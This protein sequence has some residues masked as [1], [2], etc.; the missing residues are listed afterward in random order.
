MVSTPQRV[1]TDWE[2]WRIPAQQVR[3]VSDAAEAA[4][5]LRALQASLRA[6]AAAARRMA[7]A[8]G[9]AA[10]RADARAEVESLVEAARADFEADVRGL[11]AHMAAH[12]ADLA[13]AI[14]RRLAGSELGHAFV[15][16]AAAEAA[17]SLIGDAPLRV[18]CHPSAAAA[19]KLQLSDILPSADVQADADAAPDC[20]VFETRD[21]EVD[22]SVQVQTEALEAALRQSTARVRS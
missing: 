5:E 6:G 11:E 7:R 10:G 13:L 8:E 17:R 3:A 18:H 21:G 2:G 20:C 1:E 15:A 9:L 16:R 4:G 14:V 12:I 22:A 19:V